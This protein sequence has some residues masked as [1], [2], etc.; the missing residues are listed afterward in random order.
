MSE[1]SWT[2][3]AALMYLLP[4]LIGMFGMLSV[5]T[6][7]YEVEIMFAWAWGAATAGGVGLYRDEIVAYLSL[8]N[9]G[10][11]NGAKEDSS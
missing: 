6:V 8:G 4:S 2:V 7:S 9:A 10:S 1:K 11:L 5:A 3:Y